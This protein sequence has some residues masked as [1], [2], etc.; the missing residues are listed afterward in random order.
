MSKEKLHAQREKLQKHSREITV[1]TSRGGHMTETEVYAAYRDQ[2]P[3]FMEQ[4]Q[5]ARKG[6]DKD[7]AGNPIPPQNVSLTAA[8]R[9]FFGLEVPKQ[10]HITGEFIIGQKAQ[11]K[12]ILKTFLR[13]INIFG[14]N[15]FSDV[16]SRFGGDRV[17][18]ADIQKALVDYHKYSGTNTTSTIQADW[19]FIIP[20]LIMAAIRIDYETSGMYPNWI[21]QTVNITQ[22]NI[23]MPQIRRGNTMPY[24]IGEGESIPFGSVRFGQ[25][26]AG[27]FKVG[28]GFK[29]TYELLERSA[30]DLVMEFL[31]SVGTDMAIAT[32]AEA[33]RVLI[34]GEQANNSESAPIVGVL[35]TTDGF[36]FEDI[37]GATTR[38]RR[39]GHVGPYRL[40]SDESEGLQIDALPEFK[41]A[42]FNDRLSQ[43]V[44]V[45]GMPQ[46]LP[47]DVYPVGEDQ[48]MVLDPSRA[49]AQLRY[50]SMKIEERRN[51]QNQEEEMFVTDYVGFAILRRDARVIVDQTLDRA[52][53]D[54]PS[55]MDITSR[56]S[57]QFR[58]LAVA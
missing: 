6:L 31:G 55:Y 49:M 35:D 44:G 39:L 13:Q 37:K 17:T 29:I 14:S 25:K 16:A 58:R 48:V 41:G 56:I 40:L 1:G 18:T 33:M 11:D 22:E 51:P 30:I 43:L 4:L 57:E 26:D 10:D 36:T 20:E 5:A 23:K 12:Y 7:D 8:L 19:R 2:L 42:N 3:D 38:L 34:S 28:I 45:L 46:R 47:N 32:D 50:G 27:I 54:Y 53:N 15:T 9:S 24:R 52:T 21:A